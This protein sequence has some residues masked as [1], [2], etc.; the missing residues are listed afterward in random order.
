MLHYRLSVSLSLTSLET[1]LRRIFRSNLYCQASF[2]WFSYG[3]LSIFLHIFEPVWKTNEFK[4]FFLKMTLFLT[5]ITH[6]FWFIH[7]ISFIRKRLCQFFFLMFDP[8]TYV[9]APSAML[10]L[11]AVI[12]IWLS[13]VNT[14]SSALST[15]G[16]DS[17]AR[18]WHRTCSKESFSP[19]RNYSKCLYSSLSD[20]ALAT[21]HLQFRD[22]SQRLC[23]LV[24]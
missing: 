1:S 9:S 16:N 4:A 7:C 8:L 10:E 13:T 11:F 15:E 19:M 18:F 2:P 23:N 12:C 17:T 14:M 22:S 21:S 20:T 24:K 5:K 6:K 3:W